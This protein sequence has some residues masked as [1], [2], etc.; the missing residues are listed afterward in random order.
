MLGDPDAAPDCDSVDG[1][2]TDGEEGVCPLR[3]SDPTA[4]P[5]LLV[6]VLALLFS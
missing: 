3:G 6:L 2:E 4:L 1:D 5:L